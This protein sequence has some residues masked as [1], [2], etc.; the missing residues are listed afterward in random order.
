MMRKLWVRLSG[1]FLFVALLSVISLALV[2]NQTIEKRFRGYLNQANDTQ[3][4]ERVAAS[5]EAYYLENNTWEGVESVVPGPGSS[6]RDD[7]SGDGQA[8]GAA[9]G[10]GQ[11]QGN[12]HGGVRYTIVDQNRVIVYSRE[13][14]QIGQTAGEALM[15]Q[16]VPLQN[17]DEIIGWALAETPGQSVL[18]NAQT[19]FIDDIRNTLI[20]VAL[21]TGL[22]ALL[23]GILISHYISRPLIQLKGAARSVASGNL[24][25]EVNVS[26]G[27]AEEVTSLAESFNSMSRA[28]A[29]GESLRQRMTADIAH[30]LRTPVSVIRAQLQAMMDGI[31]R[32][33]LEHIAAAYNQSVHLARLV[34]DLRTLTRAEAGHLPLSRKSVDVGGL[35]RQT[36]RLFE[37]LADDARL[38]LDMDIQGD[39]PP[40]LADPDRLHQVLANLLSNALR[41]TPKDGKILLSASRNT[42]WLRVSV[43]NTG[44]TLTENEAQHV[45]ERFWRADGSRQR[46]SGGSG[47]GLSIAQQIIRLHD[48]RIWVELDEGCTRFIFEIPIH[49]D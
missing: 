46:D 25:E 3:A 26:P 5:F 14:E 38:T 28:L 2:M 7:N 27:N 30:E 36:F 18:D 41:H 42:D 33:D 35:L 15:A 8:G 48:G 22:L 24:G 20:V 12:Q 49:Q 32:P 45:F 40:T 17:G 29:E 16:A 1:A 21:I 10:P 34:E 43:S 23:A 44:I 37:P 31:H 13:A 19:Q 39:L 6:G 9:H 11:G 47:L 4:A